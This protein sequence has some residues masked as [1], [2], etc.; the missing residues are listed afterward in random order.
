MPTE[1]TT[2]HFSYFLTPITEM[3]FEQERAFFRWAFSVEIPIIIALQRYG[4]V[5]PIFEAAQ[6]TTQFI[7][8]G[9]SS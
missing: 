6:C 9:N 1:R 4:Y 7:K 2:S 8:H 3:D 5:L